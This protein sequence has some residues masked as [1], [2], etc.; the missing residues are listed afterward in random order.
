MQK[1]INLSQCCKIQISRWYISIVNI[2]LIHNSM[3]LDIH[4]LQL[5]NG[6]VRSHNKEK[7]IE[8]MKVC[9]IDLTSC[10]SPK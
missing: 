9:F 10:K 1:A 5:I 3:S 7:K 2:R 6:L 4:P 8:D